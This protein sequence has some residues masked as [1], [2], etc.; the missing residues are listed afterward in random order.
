MVARKAYLSDSSE[1]QQG[2][3]WQCKQKTLL[4]F[5]LYG[6]PALVH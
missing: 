4:Q 2:Q 5:V 6:N 3:N 1:N